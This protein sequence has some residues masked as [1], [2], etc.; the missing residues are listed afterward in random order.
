[1]EAKSEGEENECVTTDDEQFCDSSAPIA[2][3]APQATVIHPLQTTP[4][5]MAT[6]HIDKQSMDSNSS[7]E[8]AEEPCAFIVSPSRRDPNQNDNICDRSRYDSVSSSEQKDTFM[9]NPT[10]FK[11]SQKLVNGYIRGIDAHLSYSVPISIHKM[12]LSFFDGPIEFF[13]LLSTKC[14]L[15]EESI[16]SDMWYKSTST[17]SPSYDV[18]ITCLVSCV[19]DVNEETLLYRWD[20]ESL[21]IYIEEFTQYVQETKK[22][23][24]VPKYFYRN[25]FSDMVQQFLKCKMNYKNL[26][27]MQ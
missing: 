12:V 27:G 9:N 20:R 2:F 24:G 6:Y 23:E 14:K 3:A 7:D 16:W 25:Q 8:E 1:M 18:A 19:I 21:R 13:V 17:N 11:A 15:I 22:D 26:Y 4:Y 5:Q 10:F